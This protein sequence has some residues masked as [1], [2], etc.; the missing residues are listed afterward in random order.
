MMLHRNAKLG[1]AGRLA[2]VQAIEGGMS[3]KAAAAAF[4]VSPATAHRWWHRW[5]SASEQARSSLGCLGDRSS[6]PHHSPRELAAELQERICACRRQT[7]WGPRLV[8]AVTGFAHSTVW[9]V[10]KRA[11]LSRPERSPREPANSYEWPCPGDLLH[12]DVSR[13]ARF[14]RPGHAVTG[15][16]SQRSRNW[17]RPETRVGYDYAHAV[18]D[19]HSRLSFVELH[20]DERAETVT[21]FLERALAFYASHGIA[22][23][24]L[25]TDNAFSYVKN[26]SLRELLT[27][28]RI[29]HLTTEPY[30]PR[31][32]GKVE[33]FHQTMAREWGYG[34][35]YR[36]HRERTRAL[37]HWLDYYNRR[38]PHSSIGDRP[39][40]S[41]VHNVRG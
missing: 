38:R 17:M 15:D 35:A 2:L 25:M 18:V 3:M 34:V 26:R 7:G 28:R 10:L 36:S 33:R 19:D 39:P 5:R 12:M 4:S 11:G 37:P 1:L 29:R 9:K 13:Y 24:R 31:T 16:R 23:K 22:A 40:I 21:G 14:E 27:A 41:R 6:R 8:A 20:D 32:N 30:R